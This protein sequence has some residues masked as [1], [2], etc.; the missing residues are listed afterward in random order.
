VISSLG[1]GGAEKQLHLLLK[2]LDRERFAPHVASL[3]AGGPWAQNIRELGVPVT[4]LPR[5]HGAEISR[6]CALARV[7][8]T[9]APHVLQ[10]FSP[11][12][13]A[14][15]FPVGRVNRVPVLIASR[16]TEG[17]RYPGLGWTAGRLSRFL[18]RWADAIICNSEQPRRRAPRALA[19]RH[20]VIRNGVEPLRPTR[21]RA[22]VRRALGLSEVA[23]VVGS[24]GR[25]VPAKNYPLMLQVALDVLRTH[26]E[27]TFLLVGGGPLEAEL[28]SRLRHLG[29]DRKVW[30][31]GER[32]DVADLMSALDVFLLTSSREG[33]PNAVMEAM[34]VGLPCVVTDAGGSAELVVHGETGYVCPVG[35]QDGLA[36]S[37]RRLLDD[38]AARDRFA[39]AGRARVACEFS[40]ERMA[41]VTGAL[42]SR[43][44]AA[45]LSGVSLAAGEAVREPIGGCPP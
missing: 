7:V 10:T 4:E 13:T 3:S 22:D 2:Y 14:Y 19:A 21:A 34:A 37:V 6:L 1:R 15:G 18:S 44:L 43:L 45:K 20:V 32:D 9:T 12:D 17:D 26:P 25:L 39:A 41:A 5:R 8:R 11:Y 36:T 27:T 24:V 33:M 30:L 35:D 38:A 28:R 40:P 16:R 42:Y 31:T 23:P 29:L